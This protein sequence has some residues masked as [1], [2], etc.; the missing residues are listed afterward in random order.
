MRLIEKKFRLLYDKE[1]IKK[2]TDESAA[3]KNKSL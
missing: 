1:F 2:L 3:K